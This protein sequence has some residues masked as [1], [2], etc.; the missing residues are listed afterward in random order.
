MSTL[1][2]RPAA[3]WAGAGDR[4]DVTYADTEALLSAMEAARSQYDDEAAAVAQHLAS[5]AKGRGW[6][7]LERRATLINADFAMRS[8]DAGT[9]S[10]L[11]KEVAAWARDAGDVYLEARSAFVLSTVALAIGDLASTRTEG[12]HSVRLLPADAPVGVRIDHV[13]VAAVGFGAGTTEGDRRYDE[14]L[15]LATEAGDGEAM[16]VIHN[17]RAWHAVLTGDRDGARS[18]AGELLRASELYGLP[19][20]AIMVDTVARMHVMHEEFDAALAVLSPVFDGDGPVRL[21]EPTARIDCLLAAA[22]IHRRRADFAAA[23]TLLD[24]AEEEARRGG[25]L[26]S[27]AAVHEERAVWHAAQG[28]FA[29][30]FAEY[31]AFHSTSQRVSSEEAQTQA[32][33]VHAAYEVEQASRDAVRFRELAYRDALTGLWNRRFLDEELARRYAVAS[34]EGTSLTTAI[35]D[36]DHFKRINDELSHECGDEVLRALGR[37]LEDAAAVEG[38][39]DRSIAVGRLGGEE[40]AI[41]LSGVSADVAVVVCERVRLAVQDHDWSPLTGAVPVTVSIGVSTAPTGVTSP[42]ALMSDADRNLYAAKR[43]GRN[44]VMGDPAR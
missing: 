15:E 22:E 37:L 42:G 17:N 2:T 32:Q 24:R 28:D 41:V 9:A 20:K 13:L 18:H 35:V 3:P 7:P 10:V 39:A 1:L 27:T 29:A 14:V 33:L 16:L 30:A 8:G 31:V 11:A 26:A 38:A 5:V 43:S 25:L 21:G 4:L 36:V 6:V 34:R 12:L 23:A 19:L 44:R 40:F